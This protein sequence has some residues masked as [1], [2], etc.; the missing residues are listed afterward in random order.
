MGHGFS[1][2]NADLYVFSLVV[3][4]PVPVSWASLEGTDEHG[5]LIGLIGL[6]VLLVSWFYWLHL[7]I[8]WF[9]GCS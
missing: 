9:F 5:C 2:M 6:L 7:L 4:Q 1:R 3:A 8:G